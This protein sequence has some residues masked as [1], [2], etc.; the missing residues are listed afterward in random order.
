M[1]RYFRLENVNGAKG[2]VFSHWGI[3]IFSY[4]KRIADRP[5]FLDVLISAL[6]FVCAIGAYGTLALQLAQGVYSD[7]LNLAFDFD[8]YL[9]LSLLTQD[10]PEKLGFKHPL[11][12]LL[13]PFGLFLMS[14]G[15]AE[16]AAAGMVMAIFGAG[17]VVLVWW[18]LRV[19]GIRRIESF[20]LTFLFGGSST[21]LFTAMIP[22]SYGVSGFTIVLVWLIAQLRL[23]FIVSADTRWRYIGP[24]LM[25][26]A[27]ITNVVQAFIA[28]FTLAVKRSGLRAGARQTTRFG[29]VLGILFLILTMVVWHSELWMAAHDPLAAA[30]QVWW[31]QTKGVKTGISRLLES[32]LGFSF[33]APNYT[34][35]LLPETTNMRDF[36]DW[37]FAG[38]GAGASALWLLFVVVGAICAFL[39]RSYRTI[40]TGLAVALLFN[41]GL[42]MN[43]QYRG[44]VFL[45]A[46][47]THFLVF[48]LGAG[49]SLLVANR[50]KARAGYIGALILVTS[51]VAVNNIPIAMEFS[52][53]FDKPAST[54][55]AP[56]L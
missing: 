47:H 24:L 51:L 11:L 25:A 34:F 48:A 9:M 42:H 41:I 2:H 46:A 33:V 14:V 6:F 17:T 40:A 5:F 56:C 10:P 35:V 45:Y 19:S 8:P 27:T 54:C 50:P 29:A 18:F 39:H 53:A 31:L 36:R 1:A 15:L 21:Q 37:S 26:G 3:S 43:F 28:E 55:K 22:E 16:K 20:F 12:F 13:R 4:F 52:T 32:F 38:V 23:N 49:A 30:K 7:Y 44:S